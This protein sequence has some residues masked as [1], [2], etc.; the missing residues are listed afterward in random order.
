MQPCPAWTLLNRARPFKAKAGHLQRRRRR[1]SPDARAVQLDLLPKRGVE[2]RAVRKMALGDPLRPIFGH[3]QWAALNLK[4]GTV[5]VFLETGL[6]VGCNCAA[7]GE[8]CR[9][10]FLPKK[11]PDRQD[12]ADENDEQRETEGGRID[13]GKAATRNNLEIVSSPTATSSTAP[14]P[15]TGPPTGFQPLPLKFEDSK[16]W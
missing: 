16:T 10:T 6:S 7:E 13:Q 15:A 11:A 3:V 8:A 2:F 14:V 5:T 12:V 4:K 1:E 9:L